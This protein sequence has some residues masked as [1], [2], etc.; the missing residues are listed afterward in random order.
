MESLG[1]YERIYFNVNS[2]DRVICVTYNVWVVWYNSH[3][4]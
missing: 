4:T 1:T 2:I 3:F